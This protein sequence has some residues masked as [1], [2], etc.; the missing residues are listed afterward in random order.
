MINC[1]Q[2]DVTWNLPS[3]L[4]VRCF[5]CFR[6]ISKSVFTTTTNKQTNAG[7]KRLKDAGHVVEKR[8]PP[9][10]DAVIQVLVEIVRGLHVCSVDPN[11][12]LFVPLRAPSQRHVT[13]AR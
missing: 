13:G 11:R 3:L 5:F 1:Y 7:I 4:Q 8:N 6:F 2:W 12:L 10:F 9:W